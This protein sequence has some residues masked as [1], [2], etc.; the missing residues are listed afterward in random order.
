MLN[1]NIEQLETSQII[2]FFFNKKKLAFYNLE[3]KIL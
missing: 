2:K 3:T 1:K